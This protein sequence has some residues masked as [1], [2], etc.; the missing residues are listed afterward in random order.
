[1]KFIPLI[2]FLQGPLVTVEAEVVPPAVKLFALEKEEGFNV[3]EAPWKKVFKISSPDEKKN[4][5][6][7]YSEG[8][9]V[10]SIDTFFGSHDRYVV[11]R[12]NPKVD[13][14]IFETAYGSGDYLKSFAVV[15]QG[16]LLIPSFRLKGG[17]A[18]DVQ[19][20]G[21]DTKRGELHLLIKNSGKIAKV[22]INEPV[23]SVKVMLFGKGYEGS[24]IKE[25]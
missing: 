12:K 15:S 20:V 23:D 6:V 14:V 8:K 10:I 3:F 25:N 16:K 18:L 1:M 19:T 13:W 22:K 4:Q 5:Y 24:V 11:Q 7:F 17:G 2:I 21:F 9:K